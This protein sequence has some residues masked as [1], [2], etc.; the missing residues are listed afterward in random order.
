[1]R[2]LKTTKVQKMMIAHNLQIP[3]SKAHPAHQQQ[4]K[5]RV[6]AQMKAS[7]TSLLRC[8][9]VLFNVAQKQVE[10]PAELE[11]EATI[12][13][14]VPAQPHKYFLVA[15]AGPSTTKSSTASVRGSKKGKGKVKSKRQLN[16]YI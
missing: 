9:N 10:K 4:K 16:S 8:Q 13:D 3:N 5:S 1:M 12:V 2:W 7:G 11:A 15:A 6:K 14:M